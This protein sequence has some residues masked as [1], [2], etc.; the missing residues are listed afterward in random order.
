[1]IFPFYP[2]WCAVYFKYLDIEK[3]CKSLRT[4]LFAILVLTSAFLF[5][6]KASE[7]EEVPSPVK[8]S[9][10][11]D[12]NAIVP[13]KPFK[14][15]VLFEIIPHWHIYWKNS[16]DTGL[17]TKVRFKLPEGF[18]AD[19]LNW[20]LPQ[21]FTG[22]GDI[23]DYGYE[24]SLLL[25]S[26]VNVPEGLKTGSM[27]DLAAEVSWVSC[28]E[29]CIPGKAEIKQSLPV[30][31]GQERANTALFSEWKSTLPL[32][33]SDKNSPFK[34]DIRSAGKNGVSEIIHISL[35]YEK[36]LSDIELYPADGDEF[37]VGNV[38]IDDTGGKG[39]TDIKLEVRALSGR[40]IQ[41][42]NLETLIVFK[43][44]DG[45]RSGVTL[46]IPIGNY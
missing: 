25:F 24:G 9:L 27:I 41:D 19:D 34:V 22:A 36:S 45:K 8:V 42:S 10:V 7:A 18:A 5:A 21:E 29:I 1:M 32:V 3:R 13:G 14:A 33:A 39:R 23:T 43:D 2:A 37:S 15:G 17:P 4:I 20:P 16:G 28:E 12:V 31:E 35:S 30:S 6:L 11:T 26:N 46:S 44:T 40:D 38:T